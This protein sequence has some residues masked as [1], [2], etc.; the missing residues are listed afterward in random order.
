MEAVSQMGCVSSL[1]GETLSTIF[2]YLIRHGEAAHNIKEKAAKQA[3]LQ[4]ALQEGFSENDPETMERMEAARKAVL[5]DENLRDARLTVNGRRQAEEAREEMKRILEENDHLPEPHYVIVSP[6][7]R[8][9]ETC[10]LIFP[11]ADSVHVRDELV[12]RHTGKPPDT[13]ASRDSLLQKEQFKHYSMQHLKHIDSY[14]EDLEHQVEQENDDP[15]EEKEDAADPQCAEHRFRFF[16]S[17][18][19]YHQI[20]CKMQEAKERAKIRMKQRMG[21][22]TE[23]FAL[24]QKYEQQNFEF[25][26]EDRIALRKRTHK[27]LTLLAESHQNAIAAVTHKGF[28]RELERGLFGN[29]NA[30]E[31]GNCEIRVYKLL[32]S[33]EQQRLVNAERI[34]VR[35]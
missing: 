33:T 12:E 29:E 4:Q 8:T 17:L 31:F 1:E 14:L 30:Q 26:E 22:V 6:L 5:N 25:R 21:V 16:H 18:P 10:D 11:D 7:N 35:Q 34:M 15:D 19:C 20:R 23:D 28:L 9:L 3:A 2:L 27:C 32:V 13:R 24:E